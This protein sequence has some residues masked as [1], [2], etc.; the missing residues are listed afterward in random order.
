MELTGRYLRLDHGPCGIAGDTDPVFLENEFFS[1][2]VEV[3]RKCSKCHHLSFSLVSGFECRKDPEKWGDFRRGLDWG[4]WRPD[5][6]HVSLP[7]PKVTTSR[8]VDAAHRADL[9]AFVE[10]PR[11][12]NPGT[13]VSE[14]REDFSKLREAITLLGAKLEA[15]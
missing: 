8:L 7:F 1:S 3:P 5:R 10:E 13:P 11:R 4:S 6:I 15:E 14:A 2:K 9:L 12:V